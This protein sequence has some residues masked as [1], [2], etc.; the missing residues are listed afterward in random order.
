MAGGA[1]MERKVYLNTAHMCVLDR[2]AA[3]LPGSYGLKFA[4]AEAHVKGK[5]LGRISSNL[6]TVETQ[7]SGFRLCVL[8]FWS[9]LV[10]WHLAR[11]RRGA[12]AC[13]LL[14]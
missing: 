5:H 4:V 1:V 2:Y 3:S 6:T 10:Q 8:H 12:L 11:G 9:F 7:R 13:T 14:Q